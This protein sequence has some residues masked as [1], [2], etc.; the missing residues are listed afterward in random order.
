MHEDAERCRVPACM[1]RDSY[2]EWS[3]LAA[4]CALSGISVIGTKWMKH[5]PTT[6]LQSNP[7]HAPVF[8]L[9][10]L[11]VDESRLLGKVQGKA[12]Q[13]ILRLLGRGP[14]PTQVWIPYHISHS[15]SW[16]SAYDPG[17]G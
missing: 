14:P 1:Y 16:S 3:S 17:A 12:K 5:H 2:V 10:L 4:C 13:S 15:C 7:S 6:S 8:V 9:S 11:N